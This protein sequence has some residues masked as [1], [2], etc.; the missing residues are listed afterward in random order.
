MIYR[1]SLI[2]FFLFKLSEA[3]YSK[4][5]NN[6]AKTHYILAKKDFIEEYLDSYNIIGKIHSNYIPKTRNQQIYKDILNDKDVKMV[7]VS[8]S[9]GSG[10]TLF[11]T[12]QSVEFLLKNKIEKIVIT[13]PIISVDEEIGF[14]PGTIEEKMNPWLQ[15]IYD[16]LYKFFTSKEIN[17]LI[18]EKK[19][20]ICPL[21]YMRGRS[22]HNT[23]IIADEMQNSTPQQMK[24]ITTRLGINSKLI[25]T[26]DNEQSDIKDNGLL[27]ITEKI[28]NSNNRKIKRMVKI[29]KMKDKDVMRS[30]LTK[31]IIKLY[32]SENKETSETHEDKEKDFLKPPLLID[33]RKQ[34]INEKNKEKKEKNNSIETGKKKNETTNSKSKSY[35][36]PSFNNYTSKNQ[37]NDCAMIPLD[38]IPKNKLI[39]NNNIN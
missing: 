7:I 23:Y 35:N 39:N 9:T 4:N 1:I 20:E 12:T 13:R 33:L 21:G 31:S 34:M 29:V 30:S 3:F 32:E 15:P 37:N 11:A 24:M 14:L 16:I 28:T 8:G 17:K 26:G 10:K 36:V 5:M 25:I 22:F 27:D 2:I 18:E 38:Q 19:I 6:H